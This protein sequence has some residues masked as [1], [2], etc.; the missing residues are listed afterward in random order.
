MYGICTYIWLIFMVKVGKYTIRGLFG[1]LNL[2]LL[3][4]DRFSVQLLWKIDWWLGVGV[5]SQG[6]RPESQCVSFRS[7][8]HKK[9]K[10]EEISVGSSTTYYFFLEYL[11]IRKA[12]K[13][14][15]LGEFFEKTAA[16]PSSAPH[17]DSGNPDPWRQVFQNWA[18][19]EAV[20]E[21]MFQNKQ[22][23]LLIYVY[24]YIYT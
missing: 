17:D 23:D 3:G 22:A 6:K 15:Q 21:M 9:E 18:D 19:H 10:K 4:K 20:C 5:C 12:R 8:R 13:T 24:V 11:T 16:Q 2:I 7:G 14:S 1:Y